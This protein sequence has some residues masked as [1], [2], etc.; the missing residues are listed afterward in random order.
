MYYFNYNWMLIMATDGLMI[1]MKKKTMETQ[2][3]M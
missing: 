2:L 1:S 3:I